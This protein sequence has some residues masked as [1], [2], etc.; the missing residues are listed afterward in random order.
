MSGKQ[1]EF[2]HQKLSI[3]IYKQ[4]KIK[5]INNEGLQ[6]SLCMLKE[7]RNLE[8]QPRHSPNIRQKEQNKLVRERYLQILMK[9]N[10][11]KQIHKK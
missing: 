5:T 4:N 10:F 3:I 9:S 1:S 11:Q 6:V 7:N 8:Q 2:G